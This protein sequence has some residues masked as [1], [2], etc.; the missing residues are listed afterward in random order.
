MKL[1]Q[2]REK[3]ARKKSG[4]AVTNMDPEEPTETT[5]EVAEPEQAEEKIETIPQKAKDIKDNTVRARG[6]PRGQNP[7]PKAILKRKKATNYWLWAGAAAAAFVA[8]ILAIV[9]YKHLK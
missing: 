9:G 4:A 3:R 7:F 1:I 2:E 8:L 5:A 6:H